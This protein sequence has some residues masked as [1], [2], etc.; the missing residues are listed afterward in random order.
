LRNALSSISSP[1]AF[2]AVGTN[3][4][5]RDQNSF[6]LNTAR[7]PWLLAVAGKI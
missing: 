7:F 6:F 5:T 1:S 4:N 3:V 2:V